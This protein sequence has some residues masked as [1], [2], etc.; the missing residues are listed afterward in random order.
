MQ[1]KLSILAR[2]SIEIAD[3]FIQKVESGRAKSVETYADMKRLKGVAETFLKD[4]EPKTVEVNRNV[5]DR[6]RA[7][8][9]EL[10]EY[11]NHDSNCLYTRTVAKEAKITEAQARRALKALVRKGLAEYVRGLFDEDGMVAGSGY[12]ATYEG[13][14]LVNGCVDCHKNIADMVTGQ[15]E[16]CWK[17]NPKPEQEKLI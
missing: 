16:E 10:A 15:C 11:W 4:M 14:L 2:T 12:C 1:E 9:K 6:E 13:A 17:K 8:L 5:S 3:K 7:V